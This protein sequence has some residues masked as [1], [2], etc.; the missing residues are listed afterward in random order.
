VGIRVGLAA[1]LLLSGCTVG[2]NYESPPTWSPLSW[3]RTTPSERATTKLSL[4]VAEPIDV[5]WWDALHDKQ[6]TDLMHR[7]A[8]GN[9]DVRTQEIRLAEARAQRGVTR[10]GEFPTVN[11]NGSYT[12][13]LP[14]AQGVLS[15]LSS[16]PSTDANGLGGTNG[17]IPVT[18][19]HTSIGAFDLF[20]GGFDASW[21]LDLWGRVRRQVES[22]DA[23][24]DASVEARRQTLLTSLAELARNYVQLRGLQESE[25]ITRN[26]LST[27]NETV[28]LTN[29]R[30]QGGLATDLDVAQARAQAETTGANLPQ[31]EAQEQQAINAISL[32]LGE[33][34]GALAAELET[35]KPVPP[36]PPTVPIGLPSELARRR[37]DIRQAEA[38][39]HAATADIGA[40]EADFY[41]KVTLSG[42]LALQATQFHNL[43]GTD[44]VTYGLG[45]SLTIPIF[46]GGRLRRTLELRQAQQKEAAVNYQKT[47]LQAFHDVDNALISYRA[48][49]LRR[50]RIAAEAAQSRRA[51][52]LASDR[53]KNGL[54]DYLEVLTAQRTLLGAEQATSVTASWVR[55]WWAKPT[56]QFGSGGVAPGSQTLSA[57]QASLNPAVGKISS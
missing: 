14:S 38:Q 19:A 15:L 43:F 47:V 33:P 21:E 29:E 56:A 32:L 52:S 7:V 23:Q 34:P 54:S 11:A 57:S 25:R 51:L 5:E 24:V 18:A 44:A 55:W 48:D 1:L 2:P 37:P 12:R 36:V 40:A 41:P 31:L 9:L 13:E 3:F 6:L 46:E 42:S 17:G 10:A 49:Q 50:D 4:P 26:N 30:F 28:R 39:L 22:A 53:Y 16:S 20:Q 27:A 45:P 35:R 8:G